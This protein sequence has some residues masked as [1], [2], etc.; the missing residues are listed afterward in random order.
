VYGLSS[1]VRTKVRR[2]LIYVDFIIIWS[3]ADPVEAGI[4]FFFQD[5][6]SSRVVLREERDYKPEG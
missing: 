2:S 4:T 3:D 5:R 6:A 1:S